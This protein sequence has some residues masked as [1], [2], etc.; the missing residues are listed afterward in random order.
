MQILNKTINSAI[1]RKFIKPLND[2]CVYNV[3]K[4]ENERRTKH[5][6]TISL[7]KQAQ[8]H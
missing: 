7:L 5:N 4:L 8:R 2:G 1:N 6:E 3:S